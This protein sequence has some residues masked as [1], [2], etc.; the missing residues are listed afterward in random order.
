MEPKTAPGSV[1]TEQMELCRNFARMAQV[2]RSFCIYPKNPTLSEL[3]HVTQSFAEAFNLIS[4]NPD[5]SLSVMFEWKFGANAGMDVVYYSPPSFSTPTERFVEQTISNQI[6][7]KISK[8]MYE[9][10]ARGAEY[11]GPITVIS[12]DSENPPVIEN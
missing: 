6:L 9:D 1:D 12:D 8:V 4:E 5:W 3:G 2:S 7:Q 11:G 10:F